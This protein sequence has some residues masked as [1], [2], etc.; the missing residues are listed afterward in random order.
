MKRPRPDRNDTDEGNKL[1]RTQ[2]KLFKTFIYSA[3]SLR[4]VRVQFQE[5]RVFFM[6]KVQ[7]KSFQDSVRVLV[8]SGD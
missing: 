8:Q 5:Q 2:R 7:I 1:Q 4:A 3:K 6:E